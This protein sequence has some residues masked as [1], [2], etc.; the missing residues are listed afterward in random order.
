MHT[1]ALITVKAR[2]INIESDSGGGSSSS[3]AVLT[4]TIAAGSLS[5]LTGARLALRRLVML[6]P[7]LFVTK[8]YAAIFTSLAAPT[9]AAIAFIAAAAAAA[10]PDVIR[11]QSGAFEPLSLTILLAQISLTHSRDCTYA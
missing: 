6:L 5:S 8:W 2:M 3:K 7:A 9:R 1:C 11:T 10:A 4:H